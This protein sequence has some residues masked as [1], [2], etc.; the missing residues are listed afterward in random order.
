MRKDLFIIG[1]VFILAALAFMFCKSNEKAR[2]TMLVDKVTIPPGAEISF[3]KNPDTGG[4]LIVSADTTMDGVSDIKINVANIFV[5][6]HIC[7]LRIAYPNETIS[8]Y[9]GMIVSDP[10]TKEW[11]F[12]SLNAGDANVK[13]AGK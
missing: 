4:C 10:I 6:Q 8:F 1:I 12:K 7:F 3:Q 5:E 9:N 13:L 2:V 11:S